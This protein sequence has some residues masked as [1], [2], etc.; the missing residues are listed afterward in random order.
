MKGSLFF[1]AGLV[2]ILL[3]YRFFTLIGFLL[4]MW[5]MFLMFRSFLKTIYAY[6]QTLPVIGPV[7]RDSVMISN[8]V[9]WVSS[10]GNASKSSLGADVAKFEV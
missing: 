1:F 7:L 10:K 6:M 9:N 2:M 3:G 8:A 4:Q 5:G